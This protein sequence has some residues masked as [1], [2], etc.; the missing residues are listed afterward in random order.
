MYAGSLCK[1][2]LFD[3]SVQAL[4]DRFL[5]FRTASGETVVEGGKARWCDEEVGGLYRRLLDKTDSLITG[6]YSKRQEV[7]I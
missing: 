4:G 7:K 3:S 6:Q 2:D 1:L 5:T